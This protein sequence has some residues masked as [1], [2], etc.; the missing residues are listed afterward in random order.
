MVRPV[1]LSLVHK[2]IIFGQLHQLRLIHHITDLFLK[3][4]M[5]KNPYVLNVTLVMTG[6]RDGIRLLRGVLFLAIAGTL[7]GVGDV[8]PTRLFE[9]SGFAVLIPS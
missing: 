5:W 4:T 2:F 8:G 6:A 7:L 9:T 1:L 3:H